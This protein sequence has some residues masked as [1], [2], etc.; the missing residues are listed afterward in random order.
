MSRKISDQT[1]KI[2]GEHSPPLAAIDGFWARTDFGQGPVQMIVHPFQPTTIESAEPCKYSSPS[3]LKPHQAKSREHQAANNSRPRHRLLLRIFAP[4]HK[5]TLGIHR[6]N[7][8]I[9]VP[10][11]KP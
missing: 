2:G 6:G 1:I 4:L 7:S 8:S 11:T 3:A 9:L 10:K 5:I